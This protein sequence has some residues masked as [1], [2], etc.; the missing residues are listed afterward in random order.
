MLKSILLAGIACLLAL[1]S[2]GSAAEVRFRGAFTLV[3]VKNC[4]AR[5]VGET[6][7]SA[8]RPAGLGDNPNVTSLTQF[9]QFSGDVYEFPNAAFPLNRWVRVKGHGIDNLHYEFAARIKIISQE[10]QQ[11]TWKT[12][13]VSLAGLIENVGTDPGLGGTCIASFRGSYFRRVE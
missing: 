10:P 5:Y 1:T 13:S 7:S 11:I 8:F 3:S 2:A 12:R 9:N 6:F 4:I